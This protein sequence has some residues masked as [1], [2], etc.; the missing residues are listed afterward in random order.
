MKKENTSNSNL[1][2]INHDVIHNFNL[3]IIMSFYKR[4]DDFARVLPLN[5]PYLQR[6]GIEVIIVMD[7]PSEKNKVLNLIKEYPFINWVLIIN[8]ET[9]L[10]RNHAPV[11]N[12]GIRHSSKEY[13]LQIDPEIEFHTD[14]I[15]ILRNLLKHYPKHYVYGAMAYTSIDSSINSSFNF[16]PYGNLMVK[17]EFLEQINGYDETFLKWG[18]EDDNIRKRLDFIGVKGL[19]V[20]EAQTIHREHIYT[21]NERINKFKKHSIKDIRKIFYPTNPIANKK[22]WGRSFRNLLYDWKNNS[23]SEEL[24]FKYL[25]KY[26]QFV[27]A[28]DDN[29]FTKSYKK[30]VLCQVYNGEEFIVDF[31]NNMSKYFDGIILL[32][33]ESTDK[34]WELAEHKKLLLKVK[35]QRRGFFDIE[36]RNI[37][38]DLV[39]FFK[40]E[41][42][43]FMDVDERFD[44]RYDNFSQFENDPS[45]QAVTFT[46]VYL[47]DSENT[48]KGD[49]PF[50][51]KGLFPVTRM[52]RNI[53]YSQI[54]TT[55]KLHFMACPIRTNFFQSK[56]LF[57]DY[58]SLK[59]TNRKKKYDIYTQE[60]DNEYY[61]CGYDYLLNSDNLRDLN[62]LE[63]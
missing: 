9:H 62:K 10:P 38:L 4:Y 56:I 13:I 21:P 15:Y 30:L 8:D 52:F 5:A 29:I 57:K 20:P 6:N 59:A 37:L 22:S 47:W 17:K 36:N 28:T 43:C 55:R 31:L 41:W 44:S 23:F 12:V 50:S 27:V 7:E 45:I 42:I 49:F 11:L 53:G 18:G 46:G 60:D 54:N 34:T 25:K 40:T 2:N 39:S 26:R 14:I 1:T 24:C 58:G 61:V 32:D 51:K 48:Y 19:F 63:L 33:D 35:K 3:S 16:I